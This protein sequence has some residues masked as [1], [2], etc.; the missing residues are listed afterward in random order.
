GREHAERPLG[1]TRA[2]KIDGVLVHA[3]KALAAEREADELLD[4]AF[5]G[6]DQRAQTS[7]GEPFADRHDHGRI[8]AREALREDPRDAQDLAVR[9]E[10][11]LGAQGRGELLALI[12]VVLEVLVDL[13]GAKLD[14]ALVGGR[15]AEI[16]G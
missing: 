4:A 15:E 10:H 1:S 14:A 8:A 13:P 12:E 11:D 9:I 6:A 7:P 3:A 2:V 5:V 16:A